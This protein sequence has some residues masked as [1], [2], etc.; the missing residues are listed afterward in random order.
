MDRKVSDTP[1]EK[2]CILVGLVFFKNVFVPMS[3]FNLVVASQNTPFSAPQKWKMVFS[4]DEK[5]NF[6]LQH[7]KTSQDT[8]V[9]IL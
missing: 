9:C 3:I 6:L 4:R 2:F 8:H 7:R 5:E 1:V